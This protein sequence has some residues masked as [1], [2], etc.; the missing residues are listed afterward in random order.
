MRLIALDLG[1]RRTGVAFYDT[2]T[3][4]VVP[5][6][7]LQCSS[8]VE[9]VGAL[10]AL[11]QERSPEHIIVGLPLLPSGKEGEQSAW[12]REVL[13]KLAPKQAVHFV[14]ERY[15]TARDGSVDPDAAAACELLRGFLERKGRAE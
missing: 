13:Q 8:D 3:D 12:V 11:L 9:L 14:D 6:N 4:I 15:S 2:Q 5:L 7:V 1:K 10:Q